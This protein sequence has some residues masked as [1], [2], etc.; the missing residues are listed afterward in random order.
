[1]NSPSKTRPNW[2]LQGLIV[3]SLG[4]HLVVFMHLAGIYKSKTLTYI[5]LTLRDVSKPPSRDIPRPR[6][7][8]KQAVAPRSVERLQVTP[9]PVPSLKPVK[10][11]PERTD[12]PDSL[13]EPIHAPSLPRI[14]GVAVREWEPP[15]QAEIS[16]PQ[17]EPPPRVETGDYATSTD[18]FSMVRLKI[19]NHKNY[20]ASARMR[21]IE[22]RTTLRFVIEPDGRIAGVKVVKSARRRSLDRAA[23]RAVEKASPFPRPPAHL[24]K[25]PIA[26]E[27]T[28]VFELT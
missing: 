5:E 10:P 28:L 1:V 23:V 22:G 3:A 2:L 12:V 26:L 20:P 25:G 14:P 19:E 16:A 7:R 15:H 27:V 13:V 9:R 21:Q 6:S 18:Y 17:G 11:E 4:I 8:P 24:F